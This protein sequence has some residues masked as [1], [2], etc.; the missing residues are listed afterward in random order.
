VTII[1]RETFESSLKTARAALTAL[2]VEPYEAREVAEA[3]RRQN[4]ATLAALLPHFRDEAK[5]VAIAKSGRQELEENLKRD[6]EARQ[7]QSAGGWD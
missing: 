5:T 4:L 1:E 6:R 2:G 3:F 7:R